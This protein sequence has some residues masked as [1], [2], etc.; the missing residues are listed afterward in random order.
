[1]ARPTISR[2]RCLGNC[3]HRYTHLD[4]KSELVGGVLLQ[5]GGDYCR[6]K[7]RIRRFVP[8]DA[9]IY[10][11]KWCPRLKA[12]AEYRI[13]AFKN[14]DTWYLCQHMGLEQTPSAHRYAIRAS[15]TTPMTASS[16]WADVEVSRPDKLL[17]V[18][19]HTGEIVEIDDGITP[20]FFHVK[21]D[22]VEL[23]PHFDP[24][25]A[26]QNHYEGGDESGQ[27]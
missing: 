12:P 9:K 21:E 6:A 7:K 5:F 18:P 14:V 11:P 26:K 19:V 10:V 27:L 3:P 20:Y 16:F 1:M 22:T 13:Y 4:T 17:G 15:G 2:P 24:E 8:N 23:L 25:P